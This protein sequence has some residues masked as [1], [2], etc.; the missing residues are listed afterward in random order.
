VIGAG[1]IGLLAVPPSQ[2]PE[3]TPMK[4]VHDALTAARRRCP[5]QPLLAESALAGGREWTCDEATAQ[6]A[7][8]SLVR[9]CLGRLAYYKAPGWVI[10]RSELP[11]TATNKIQ[12]N[13]LF[14]AGLDARVGAIDCRA[15]KKRPAAPA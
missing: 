11:V 12:K 14:E 8:Q 9:H 10:F 13:R 3:G 2:R 5:Q 15:L 6:A 1:A 4:T 7:A